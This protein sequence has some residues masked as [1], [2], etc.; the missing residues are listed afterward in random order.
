MAFV[1]DV[2][3]LLVSRQLFDTWQQDDADAQQ[4]SL[5]AVRSIFQSH[6]LIPAMK[7]ALQHYATP[8]HGK[9]KGWEVLRPPLTELAPQARAALLRQLGDAG[10]QIDDWGRV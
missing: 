4:A 6:P 3:A 9:E 1:S 5:Q 10:F 7:A 2:P 8:Q